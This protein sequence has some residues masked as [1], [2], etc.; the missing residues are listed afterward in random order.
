MF[1]VQVHGDHS[2]LP[3]HP[4][5]E[6]SASFSGNVFEYLLA[7]FLQFVGFFIPLYPKE[8]EPMSECQPVLKMRYPK[9]Q[10]VPGVE[11]SA[12]RPLNILERNTFGKNSLCLISGKV[13]S[14]LS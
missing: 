3:K 2:Q 13:L 7:L 9:C 4:G 6:C 14:S 8:A 5:K 12:P 10:A 1:Y 11:N